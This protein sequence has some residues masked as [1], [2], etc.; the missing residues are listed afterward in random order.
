MSN[1]SMYLASSVGFR[2]MPSF[3]SACSRSQMSLDQQETDLRTYTNNRMHHAMIQNNIHRKCTCMISACESLP[4]P[5]RSKS[6][7]EPLTF[8][9]YSSWCKAERRMQNEQKLVRPVHC[10]G[11]QAQEHANVDRI[12]SYEYSPGHFPP[13]FF[14]PVPGEEAGTQEK[15]QEQTQYVRFVPWMKPQVV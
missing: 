4:E 6:S 9:A 2:P 10:N 8:I 5:S 3:W 14:W 7:K 12:G 13:L 1:L 11:E 15:P